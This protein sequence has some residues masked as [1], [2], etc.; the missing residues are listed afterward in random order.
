MCITELVVE[1]V[2]TFSVHPF[3]TTS[4]FLLSEN[5]LFSKLRAIPAHARGVRCPWT[6][7]SGYVLSVATNRFVY[8]ALFICISSLERYYEAGA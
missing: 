7:H 1:R 6:G 4:P 3:H 5:L 2:R 8:V